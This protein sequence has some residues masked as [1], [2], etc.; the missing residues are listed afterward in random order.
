MLMRWSNPLIGALALLRP[1]LFRL[2][3]ATALGVLSLGSALTL[4][5][6]SAWLITRA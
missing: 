1:R 4:A 2:L 3:L 5:G 6:L